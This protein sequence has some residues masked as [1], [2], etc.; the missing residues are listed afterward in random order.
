MIDA[1]KRA[2]QLRGDDNAILHD[3]GGVESGG[4]IIDN[5]HA[6]AP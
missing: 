5:M 1:M 4:E 3:D 2:N 6:Y